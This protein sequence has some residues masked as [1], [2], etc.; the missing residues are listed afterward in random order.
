MSFEIIAIDS[1]KRAV[2]NLKSKFAN[3]FNHIDA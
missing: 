2:Q 1:L 3:F